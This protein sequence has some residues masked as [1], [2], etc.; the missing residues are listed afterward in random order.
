MAIPQIIHQTYSSFDSLSPA[1]RQNCKAIRER[2]SGYEYRFYCNEERENFI[3]QHYGADMLRRYLRIDSRYGAARADLFRYLCVYQEGGIY[4]DVKADP[5]VPLSERL[6]PDDQYILSQWDHSESSPHAGW[7]NHP[8]LNGYPGGAFQ[9]WF[10]I[11]APRH[12]FLAAV[13]EKVTQNIDTFDAIRNWRNS[14]NTVIKTTG[15]APYSQAII[16]LLS[17]HPHR[18][19]R[20]ETDLDLH[21][22]V[23][24]S[25]GGLTAHHNRHTHYSLQTAPLV[26]QPWPLNRAFD[27]LGVTRRFIRGV[28]TR[29]SRANTG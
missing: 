1:I 15:E 14:W 18:I 11:A 26:V 23:L 27:L 3:R 29:L 20:V 22:S 24:L 6:R 21:Y 25:R 28:R 16:P 9:Q 10:L 19:V 4:L 17:K 8:E 2:H 13:I 12:P 7:G 5:R